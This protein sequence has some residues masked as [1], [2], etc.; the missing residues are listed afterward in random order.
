MRHFSSWIASRN[1]SNEASDESVEALVEAVQGRYS[2]AQRWYT[3]KAQLL[4]IDKLADYDRMASVGD[5]E[6]EV[7]WAEAQALVLDAYGSFSGE[8]A[9]TARNFFDN[10]WIDAPARAG[11][12]PGRVVRVH[13]AVASSVSAAQLD[14]AAP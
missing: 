9:D 7:G 13:R 12:A 14:V 2:I 11:Q 10:P 5:V 3:L 6:S 1:L 8:L 4:G